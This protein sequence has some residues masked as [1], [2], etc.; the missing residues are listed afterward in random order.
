MP[1]ARGGIHSHRSKTW[2]E[3]IIKTDIY[4]LRHGEIAA[5][6]PF[7]FLGQ[8]DPALTDKGLT[9]IAEVAEIFRARP[10]GLI[11]SSDL[12]R[13]RI[14]AEIIAART[15][16]QPPRLDAGLREINL[17]AWEGLSVE[18]VRRRF[19]G[20]YEQRG[21]SPAE[22]A[23]EGGESFRR[24]QERAAASLEKAIRLGGAENNAVLIVTHAGVSRVLMAQILQMPLQAIFRLEHYY[25][26][27]HHIRAEHGR[28]QVLGLNLPARSFA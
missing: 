28:F 7:R 14:S 12:Q 24:L 6:R 13:C 22:Y 17:G 4:L 23:P 25:A 20:A 21:A 19:P 18:E 26:H 8:G 5:S 2:S 9:Q 27:I 15:S 1:P 11:L 16:G 3:A 10:F